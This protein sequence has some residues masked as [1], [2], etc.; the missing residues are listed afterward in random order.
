[1]HRAPVGKPLRENAPLT[2]AL[3]QVEHRVEKPHTNP[4]SAAWFAFAPFQQ[5]TYQLELHPVHI[6]WIRF[7]G[8]ISQ[9]YRSD[10]EAA[11]IYP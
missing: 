7:P 6:A 11:Y 5:R 2:A 8:S 1:M 3:E 4:L 10:G 9:I